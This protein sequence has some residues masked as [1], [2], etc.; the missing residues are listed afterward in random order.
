MSMCCATCF[1][2]YKE[3]GMEALLA[4]L[5]YRWECGHTEDHTDAELSRAE[6][7]TR[8]LCRYFHS[9]TAIQNRQRE[10]N[11][12][13]FSTIRDAGTSLEVGVL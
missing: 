1:N 9:L 4:S 7:V 13:D 12:L 11:Y 3:L 2:F 5:R 10:K 6:I 8:E